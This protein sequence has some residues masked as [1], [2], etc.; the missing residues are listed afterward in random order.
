MADV[1]RFCFRDR[2][3]E[4]VS[5][6]PDHPESDGEWFYWVDLGGS[7]TVHAE[8]VLERFGCTDQRHH[9]GL[10]EYGA[11][12]FTDLGDC[13]QFPLLDVQL[14]AADCETVPVTVYFGRNFLLTVH[15][16]RSAML[17]GTRETYRRS[18]E[19]V[20][21]SPGFL[22]FELADH[23]SQSFTR[24]IQNLASRTE[25]IEIELF[26]EETDDS[27]FTRVSGLMRSILVLYKVIVTARET[28][29]DL[30]TRRSPF[31]PESTQP[32]LDK[33]AALLDRLSLDV[34]TEREVLS[35]ALNLYMGIVSYRTNAVVTRL[36]VLSTVFLPLSF[37]VG[38]YGMNFEEMPELRWKYG[39]AAFWTLVG[40]IVGSLTIYMKRR[41]WM[42]VDGNRGRKR[43]AHKA[44]GR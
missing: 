37:L 44:A 10:D 34:T 26:L 27:I 33:E 15:R 30:A 14:S 43:A 7:E 25:R 41:G 3:L 17:D 6:V 19:Q 20:A 4:Q 8:E 42:S 36:T 32:F 38:V 29:H 1:V 2:R 5:A 39:Y 28:L 11:S 40:A 31:I 24:T 22:L 35:E 23:L 21:Q 12:R 16:S 18:F 9:R 13:I